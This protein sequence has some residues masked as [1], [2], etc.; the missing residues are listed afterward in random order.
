MAIVEPR[1]FRRW[2]W[3]VA[4]FVIGVVATLALQDVQRVARE[5]GLSTLGGMSRAPGTR[6]GGAGNEEVDI[7]IRHGEPY[8]YAFTITNDSSRDVR[9]IGFPG[10]TG[11]GVM[12]RVRVLLGPPPGEPGHGSS[13]AEET[14]TVFR[15]FTLGPDESRQVAVRG[16]FRSCFNMT[17][18]SFAVQRSIRVR[19]RRWLWTRTASVDLPFDLRFHAG[20]PPPDV[21]ACD[22]N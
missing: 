5:V 21:P 15:T 4:A 3:V 22:P 7:P 10:I 1:R 13:L 12:E 18:D 19:Y 20:T 17:A 9:I 14:S 6:T 11:G 2:R 8:E 16:Q